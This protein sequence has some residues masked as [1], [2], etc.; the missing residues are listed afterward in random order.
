MGYDHALAEVSRVPTD[1]KPAPSTGFVATS[2]IDHPGVG[3]IGLSGSKMLTVAHVV[4]EHPIRSKNQLMPRTEGLGES[5]L[6]T[7]R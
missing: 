7:V 3:D 1:L 2:L 4:L 6:H 5:A